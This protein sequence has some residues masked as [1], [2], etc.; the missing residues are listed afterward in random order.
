ML[1]EEEGFIAPR[2]SELEKG[3]RERA[4]N[5][6]SL[7]QVRKWNKFWCLMTQ[8]FDMLHFTRNGVKRGC[9]ESRCSDDDIEPKPHASSSYRS[10]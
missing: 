1:I 9:D 2:M 7:S 5:L 4:P 6:G 8:V 3:V 10:Y